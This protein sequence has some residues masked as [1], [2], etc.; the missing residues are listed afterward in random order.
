MTKID[1]VEIL[2]GYFDNKKANDEIIP[3]VTLF[4]K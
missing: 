4:S 3:M 2:L 1:N